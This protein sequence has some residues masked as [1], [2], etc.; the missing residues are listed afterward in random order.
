MK[1]KK[2]HSKILF[3]IGLLLCAGL[4][5]ACFFITNNYITKIQSETYQPSH[6]LSQMS[7]DDCV[8]FL[9]QNDVKIPE[10]FIDYPGFSGFVKSVIKTIETNPDYEFVYNYSVTQEFVENIRALVNN[11]QVT[12]HESVEQTKYTLQYNL[13]KN[14]NGNWVDNGG[15]FDISYYYYN[16]Y[17]YAIDRI[18]TP[19]LYKT[20]KQY[21]PG[22]FSGGEIFTKT[23]DIYDLA[24]GVK[25]DLEALGFENVRVNL[26]KPSALK[27]YEQLICIR[28]TTSDIPDYHLMKYDPVSDSWY[29][30][31]G[32]T[33]ILKYKSNPGDYD[34][35]S[36]FS[37]DGI[38]H[39]SNIVYDSDIYYITYA[40]YPVESVA[41]L[42][43]NSITLDINNSVQFTAIALPKSTQQIFLWESSD[44][45]IAVVSERRGV[46]TALSSGIATITATSCANKEIT[47]SIDII[48][49]GNSSGAIGFK[50][51]NFRDAVMERLL[52]SYPDYGYTWDSNLYAADLEK[53]S[54]LDVS[55]RNINGMD[56]LSYFINLRRLLLTFN[57]VSSLDLSNKNLQ[58]F[59]CF[60]NK[61][62]TLNFK[63][64]GEQYSLLSNGNGYVSTC[65]SNNIII[66]YARPMNGNVFLNWTYLGNVVSTDSAY[67]LNLRDGGD[68]IANFAELPSAPQIFST[69]PGNGQIK[70]YWTA[71]ANNGGNEILGY[72]VSMDNGL[73]W[74]TSEDSKSHIFTGLTNGAKYTFKVRAVSGV[75]YG[76]EATVTVTLPITMKVS[77]ITASAGL[78]G[79]ISPRGRVIISPGQDQAYFFI[80]DIGYEIDQVL[81]DGINDPYAVNS[82]A[83]LFRIKSV[84][85]EHTIEVTFKIKVCV[86]TFM[87]WNGSILKTEEVEYGGSATAPAILALVHSGHIFLEW[88][89]AFDYIINDLII[90]AKYIQTYS[91]TYNGLD[92]KNSNNSGTYI[93]GGG[94]DLKDPESREGYTFAGWYDADGNKAT[95]ISDTV[96][97]NL[98]LW[99]RW[100]SAESELRINIGLSKYAFIIISAVGGVVL[101]S[102]LVI[103]IRI[104]IYR[105]KSF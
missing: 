25:N 53:I 12:A 63:F 41:I 15:Y 51:P 81:I 58:A 29:H 49:T 54:N 13:V 19:P 32:S 91:I 74:I 6:I 43:E 28:R 89:T 7:E 103:F 16:C 65:F 62:T 45:E 102:V 59:D 99:A 70:L 50:D 72:E 39:L 97:G 9:I 79:S 20:D 26:I 69:I 3:F 67:T 46:V 105:K 1:T 34:W 85:E 80:P 57:N 37:Y 87:D 55:Y 101:F 61:L 88:D 82:K 104:I 98:E 96:T 52:F 56:E 14:S 100:E 60:G 73:T 4:F 76:A 77:T 33:A 31:P 95:S 92:G 75:G 30:K 38:E 48:V 40:S 42:S 94:F 78:N 21:Q 83:Y 84:D 2:I 8:E 11:Y 71:P 27:L 18:E 86:V 5:A 36:E 24:L 17:A 35:I 90:L 10:G 64:L 93:H 68:F 22:D 23:I 66:L 44:P 47:A